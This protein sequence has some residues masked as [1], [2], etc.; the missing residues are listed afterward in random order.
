MDDIVD[1]EAA[2]A[3]LRR[4]HGESVMP[5]H[6]LGS[7]FADRWCV[8]A[9]ELER[10]RFCKQLGSGVPSR[11]PDE[12]EA[13]LEQAAVEVMPTRVKGFDEAFRTAFRI[14]FADRVMAVLELLRASRRGEKN[15]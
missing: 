6:G 5:A 9:T 1:R 2:F 11:L 4:L 7:M 8:Q 12:A 10:R 15:G 3:E 14:G 13:C